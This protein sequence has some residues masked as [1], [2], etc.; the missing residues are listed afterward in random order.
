MTQPNLLKL[1]KQGD[2]TAIA[3]LMNRH[4]Q[5]K[6]IIAKA[7]LKDDCLQIML[8]SAQVPNQ[9]TLVTFVRNWISKLGSESIK[10]VKVY[11]RQTGDEFP[12][13]SQDFEA[14]S[15]DNSVQSETSVPSVENNVSEDSKTSTNQDIFKLVASP[16]IQFQNKP[17]CPRTYLFPSILVTLFACIPAGVAGI[18]FAT[19]VKNKYQQGDYDGALS[20][21]NKAKISCIIGVSVGGFIIGA[22]FLHGFREGFQ[23]AN[24]R[25]VATR[26]QLIDPY[27]PSDVTP[28]PSEYLPPIETYPETNPVRN[29][30]SQ[31]DGHA[32]LMGADNVFLG[33][34]SSDKINE[35]S[36][37]N[38]VGEFGSRVTSK[39]VWNRVGDYGSRIS[40]TSAYNTNTNQPPV[41]VNENNEIIGFL[42][43]NTRIK[44][45]VDPDLLHTAM[46]QQ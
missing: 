20:L 34:I 44:G 43:V 14:M 41:I 39:S 5:P 1:A 16:R 12:A 17:C 13:W 42:T 25:Q 4:L 27:V 46:C 23:R 32:Y 33:I 31:L 22:A 19:K 24:Q 35:K 2:A 21:S 45:A 10:R 15:V 7:I 8:E 3:S 40:D 36:I 30:L 6:G 26:Q 29:A 18:V 11:G 28:Q 37:C 38:Q 9:P